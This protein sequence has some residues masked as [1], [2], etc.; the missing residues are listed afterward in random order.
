MPEIKRKRIPHGGLGGKKA[1]AESLSQNRKKLQSITESKLS[2][3]NRQ[4]SGYFPQDWSLRGGL[5]MP[6]SSKVFK[7][8]TV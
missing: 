5:T 6:F 7:L 2:R 1:G 3:N 8:R 4:G